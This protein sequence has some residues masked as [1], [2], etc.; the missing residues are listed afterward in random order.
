MV[1]IERIDKEGGGARAGQ[2]GCD[3]CADVSRLAYAGDD[4]PSPAVV[5]HLHGTIE[6]VYI[7]FDYINGG[8]AFNSGYPINDTLK[9]KN[10]FAEAVVADPSAHVGITCQTSSAE[11]VPFENVYSVGFG[12]GAICDD[13]EMTDYNVTENF[14]S[15]EQMAAAEID[16]VGWDESFWTVVEGIPFPKGLQFIRMVAVEQITCRRRSNE[17]PAE[18]RREPLRVA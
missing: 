5:D 15:R 4:E 14:A 18:T 1:G 7:Q 11:R 6:N 3:F 17:I 9:V 12:K 2:C 13:W 16:F 8:T 10:C